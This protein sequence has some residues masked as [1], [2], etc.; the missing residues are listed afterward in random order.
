[1]PEFWRKFVKSAASVVFFLSAI[2]CRALSV[3]V[4]FLFFKIMF[5]NTGGQQICI[6]DLSLNEELILQEEISKK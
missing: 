6:R 5:M 2:N 1:V 4:V 3:N